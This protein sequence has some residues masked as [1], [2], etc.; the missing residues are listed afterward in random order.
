MPLVGTPYGRRY[1]GVEPDQAVAHAKDGVLPAP[2]GG[3]SFGV[4]ARYYELLGGPERPSGRRSGFTA[5][6]SSSGHPKGNT[7]TR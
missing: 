3:T 7:K 6:I 5:R 1:G 2:A 4:Y